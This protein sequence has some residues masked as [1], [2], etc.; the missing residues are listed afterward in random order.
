[1]QNEFEKKYLEKRK[2]AKRQCPKCGLPMKK[3]YSGAGG[4][5]FIGCSSITCGYKEEI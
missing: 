1:M 5:T 2:I 3:W 4:R